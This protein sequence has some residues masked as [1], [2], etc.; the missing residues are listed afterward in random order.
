MY[1]RDRRACKSMRF[2]GRLAQVNASPVPATAGRSIRRLGTRGWIHTSP[3]FLCPRDRSQGRR[4]LSGRVRRYEQHARAAHAE[5]F[6]ALVIEAGDDDARSAASCDEDALG[7]ARAHVPGM[8]TWGTPRTGRQ[9]TRSGRRSA[10]S[11]AT[12][13][14]RTA[15]TAR[16]A[17]DAPEAL[18]KATAA[19]TQMAR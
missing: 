11:A 19:P 7:V 10:P 14:A 8:I 6:S 17:S 3:H 9:R 18:G 2:T 13:A 16:T 5:P 12:R 4:E 1:S 15:R